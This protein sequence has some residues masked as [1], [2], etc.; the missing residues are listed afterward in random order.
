MGT[1]PVQQL[2]TACPQATRNASG[3]DRES[4]HKKTRRMWGRRVVTCDR[5][6]GTRYNPRL[7]QRSDGGLTLSYRSA[8]RSTAKR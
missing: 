5:C 3:S 1:D 8:R 6:R 7:H 2:S 4:A